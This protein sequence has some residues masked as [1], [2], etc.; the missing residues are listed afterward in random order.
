MGRDITC[1]SPENTRYT[2]VEDQAATRSAPEEQLA[3]GS[4]FCSRRSLIRQN[5]SRIAIRFKNHHVQRYDSESFAR[6]YFMNRI[7]T[8]QVRSRFKSWRAKPRPR[9]RKSGLCN[10]MGLKG[11]DGGTR[12]RSTS[13]MQYK[14]WKYAKIF[15]VYHDGKAPSHLIQHRGEQ[16][17]HSSNGY[18]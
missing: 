14:D 1:G 16:L 4:S 11:T 15:Q 12:T 7:R 17:E 10:A 5:T 3:P 13:S 18:V 6:T 9:T 8:S 2:T